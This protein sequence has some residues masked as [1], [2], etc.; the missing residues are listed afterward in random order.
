MSKHLFIPFLA[1]V[2]LLS[3]CSRPKP[4]AVGS[5]DTT[6]QRILAEI[7]AQHLEHRFPD[8]EIRR[9]FDLGDT[10]TVHQALLNSEI[11]LYPEYSGLV[12]TE[13]LK[14][15]PS[16]EPSVVLERTRMELKRISL[17]DFVAPFGFEA[18]NVLVTRAAD[19]EKFTTS[20]EAAASTMRWKVGLSY[21]FQNKETGLPSFNTYRFDMGAPLRSMKAEELFKALSDDTVS[22]IIATG[23]DG[24]LLQSGFK[25]LTDD[26]KAF[27]PMQAGL[28]VRDDVLSAEPK[29]R[30]ALNE[31]SGKITLDTMR[32]L[33]AEVDIDER[34]VTDVAK[35]FLKSAG[36]SN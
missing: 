3:S 6:E 8:T 23:T 7:T 24:H 13:L 9:R 22:L 36:L 17:L 5:K 1:I 2:C 34:K 35:D 14:E 10:R 33:N 32:K 31:L 30:S 26:M 18:R 16:D 21:E 12:V 20:S 4:I 19:A 29:L 27:P 11:G 25:V 15:V 28:I